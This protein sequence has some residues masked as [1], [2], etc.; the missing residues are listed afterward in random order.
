MVIGGSS[1]K[2]DLENSLS[3][4]ELSPLIDDED[5]NEQLPL[6]DIESFPRKKSSIFSSKSPDKKSTSTS[7]F[8]FPS[9]SENH[10]SSVEGTTTIDIEP[11]DSLDDYQ[12]RR[13]INEVPNITVTMPSEEHHELQELEY[14]NHLDHRLESTSSSN[15]ANGLGRST[16]DAII[17]VEMPQNLKDMSSQLFN[18][19]KRVEVFLQNFCQLNCKNRR[20]GKIILLYFYCLVEAVA[21]LLS[22]E[23]YY[24]NSP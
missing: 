13:N 5:A 16:N 23:F 15:S 14:G 3:R 7:M 4:E 6:K 24:Y 22:F 18:I 10:E 8:K 9:V 21:L 17:N 19:C 11:F 1:S 2:N 12:N 20:S